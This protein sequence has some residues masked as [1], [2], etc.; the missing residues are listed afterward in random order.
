MLPD[1]YHDLPPGKIASVVTYLEMRTP[2]PSMDLTL[3]PGLSIVKA[4]PD[5]AAYREVFRAAGENWLWFSRLA[6]PDD[7]LIEIL[8][9]PSVDIFFL[10][11]DS[12][13]IGLAELDRRHRPDVELAF[14]G[15]VPSEIG[16]GL[17]RILIHH[18]IQAA[19]SHQPVRLWL[20]TCTLDHPAALGFYQRAGFKPYRRAVEI[21][22]DPRLTGK[23]PLEAAP[24][25][26]CL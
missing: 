8:S 20:H 4:Q 18:A 11:R 13:P 26:P 23:L 6:M 2:P 24:Q 15:I 10:I 21:A 16:K 25:V 3:P 5:P 12:Q 19:W 9:H 17:G 22:P 7:Q 1:G 14:L